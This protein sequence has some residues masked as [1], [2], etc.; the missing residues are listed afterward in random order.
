MSDVALPLLELISRD[1]PVNREKHYLCLCRCG[2]VADLV[3]L[4]SFAALHVKVLF[5]RIKDRRGS[6]ELCL[7]EQILIS[8]ST[9]IVVY[10]LVIRIHHVIQ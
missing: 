4:V 3:F 7:A 1:I 6:Y 9:I 5:I 10:Y 8:M 2:R